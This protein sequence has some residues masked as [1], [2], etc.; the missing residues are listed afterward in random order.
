ME[1]FLCNKALEENKKK[2]RGKNSLNVQEVEAK[3]KAFFFFLK[4]QLAFSFLPFFFC[5]SWERE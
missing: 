2:R 3:K 4:W 1:Q 5:K